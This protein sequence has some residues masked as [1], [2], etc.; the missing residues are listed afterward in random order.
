[1]ELSEA[2]RFSIEV[3]VLV[4]QIFR[5]L[6]PCGW[7]E[8]CTIPVIGGICRAA[9]S[10]SNDSCMGRNQDIHHLVGAIEIC[11]GS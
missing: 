7:S 1:M 9:T 3:M 11:N 2:C 6:F 4:G 10:E 8:A 5:A